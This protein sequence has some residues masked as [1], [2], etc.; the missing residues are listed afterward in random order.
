[1]SLLAAHSE[2]SQVRSVADE[3]ASMQVN[4]IEDN[5]LQETKEIKIKKSTSFDTQGLDIQGGLKL[6]NTLL[7]AEG[8]LSKIIL[9]TSEATFDKII[10]F[11][12][13]AVR[14]LKN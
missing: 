9:N 13:R 2:T 5:K 11:T 1:M 3:S 4:A 14:P 6:A 8:V 10:K 12:N 7:R